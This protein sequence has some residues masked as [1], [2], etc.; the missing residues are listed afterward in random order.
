[1]PEKE[2]KY[3]ENNKDFAYNEA[4]FAFENR[5]YHAYMLWKERFENERTLQLHLRNLQMLVDGKDE[6]MDRVDSY[7]V[8]SENSNA[9]R[10]K[11]QSGL[12]RVE[13]IPFGFDYYTANSPFFSRDSRFE[14]VGKVIVTESVSLSATRS[15]VPTRSVGIFD[16]REGGEI[17]ELVGIQLYNSR[18]L[19]WRYKELVLRKGIHSDQLKAIWNRLDTRATADQLNYFGDVLHALDYG[20]QLPIVPEQN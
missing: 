5:F 4:A 2:Y 9:S 3:L 18:Y 6:S 20:F 17:G 12:S 13:Y 16:L 11:Q 15:L 7:S 8:I 1:M 19:G 10:K 14:S